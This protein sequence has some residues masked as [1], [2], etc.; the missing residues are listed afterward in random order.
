MQAVK[1][2]TQLI[3]ESIQHFSFPQ[4][5]ENLYQ[6]LRYFLALGGKRIRPT[7]TLLAA[8]LFG[9][10]KENALPS[11]LAVE[12][13]HNFSLIH[14]DI[15]DEAPL[16]RK[17]QTVHEK[18][19][20][21][22]AILSG[23]VLLIKAYQELAKQ[24]A[25]HIPNLLNCFNQMAVEVCEGQQ[26]DMDFESE[27]EIS[28]PDYIDMIRLKTSV[29]LGCAL[30]MGA[31]VANASE[32]NQRLIYDFGVNIGIAFQIQ[33]DILDLYADP[34]KFG[35]QVGGDVLSN[36]KTF[37]LLKAFEL[38]NDSQKSELTSLLEAE[39]NQEKI[40]KVRAIFDT[41]EVKQE[42]RKKMDFYYEQAMSSLQQIN[43]AEETKQTLLELAAY[44]LHREE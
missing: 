42:A 17:Q 41:L 24:N 15:M 22:I 30:Q 37:L 35:K 8:E 11:A 21:P 26:K 7:L 18:W 33:D 13:F 27:L 4:T 12:I 38:A 5:P 44:L 40:E 36:K 28:I 31:I 23:D 3:E 10:E 39:K 6:P 20:L 1:V 19:N 9:T 29:L 32:E 34:E 16:R 14:D 2:S 25:E 43:V